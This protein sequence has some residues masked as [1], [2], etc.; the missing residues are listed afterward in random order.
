MA[1]TGIPM[2][3]T[4]VDSESNLFCVQDVFSS[5]LVD[6]VLATPWLELA[7]TRQEGQENWSRRRIK[8]SAISWLPQWH[9]ELGQSWTTIQ[10]QLDIK[11]VPYYGTA[12]WLDEPGFTCGMHTDGE[13]PGSLHMPW[14]GTGTSFY[15]YK[16]PATLRYQVPPQPNSGY[17]MINQADST[18]FRKLIWHG[19][20]KPVPENTFRVTSYTWLTPQ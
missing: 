7:W 14:I 6:Q 1:G 16:D 17:I 13:L 4:A 18:G 19:M 15:W 2:Q 3:I 9:R 10:Q 11:L 12:F 20:L 5:E 8:D